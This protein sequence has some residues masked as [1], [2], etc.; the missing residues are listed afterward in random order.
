MMAGRSIRLD[1]FVH[2]SSQTGE[3]W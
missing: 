2:G 1:H 3:K